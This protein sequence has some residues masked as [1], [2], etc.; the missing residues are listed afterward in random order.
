M[1]DLA[2]FE[3]QIM[4]SVSRKVHERMRRADEARL[5]PEAFGDPEEIAEAMVAALPL[6]HVF[7]EITGPFYDTAGLTRWL[8]V[9]RQA[10]HQKVARY[11]ILACPLD[12]GGVVYPAWQ[13][14]DSGATIPSL[15]DVLTALTEGADDP[16]MAALWMRAPS[17]RLDGSCPADWLC[18]GGDPQRVIEMARESAASWS[19]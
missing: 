5:G 6:G 9:S 14:L 1:T 8:G 7:D 17:D 16:W 15:R 12:E 4:L 19:A 10:L 18:Q 2:L 3:H 11:A 13:F